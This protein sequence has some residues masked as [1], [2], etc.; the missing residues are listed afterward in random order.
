MRKKCIQTDEIVV[1]CSGPSLRNVDVFSLGL[2]VVAISTAIRYIAKPHIWIYAD[3]LN[4]MHGEEG[5]L[6][7]DNPNILKIVPSYK[8]HTNS[9]N[10]TVVCNYRNSNKSNNLSNDLFTENN[11]FIRGPHK[12]VTLAI[13]ILHYLGYKTLIFAGNDLGAKSAD[14]RYAY[15]IDPKQKKKSSNYV[16][17]LSQTHT[18]FQDWYPF[19]LKRGFEWYSWKCGDNFERIVPPFN[20]NKFTKLEDIEYNFDYDCFQN[21][22]GIVPKKSIIEPLTIRKKRRNIIPQKKEIKEE[23]EEIS[24]VLN[25]NKK[26]LVKIRLEKEKRQRRELLNSIKSEKIM[27]KSHIIKLRED[28]ILDRR[29]MR[30]DKLNRARKKL[31]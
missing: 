25:L 16:T 30:Q 17:S 18:A 3:R 31:P 23:V 22:M 21:A 19:A 13:Q 20:E 11:N 1:A 26:D 14:E 9:S 15:T 29:K 8:S 24:S 12:S 7:Q 5:K 4:E 2:P 27:T 10:N 6:A 28:T